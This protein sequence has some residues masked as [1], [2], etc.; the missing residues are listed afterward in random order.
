MKFK[1]VQ[2]ANPLDP[3]KKK[4]Y[5]NPVNTGKVSQKEIAKLVEE[6]S[7]L[8]IWDIINVIENLITELPRQLAEGK[9]VKLWDL[10]SFRLSL[11]SEG[12]EDKKIFNTSKI[13]P[14]VIFTPSTEF[15]E[16]LKK[17]SY[18]QAE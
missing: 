2:R 10:G 4:W 15:K 16:K 1:L 5:A 12:V 7:S 11:S 9:S 13:E 18:N 17:I 3:T 14:K 6:R 8:T